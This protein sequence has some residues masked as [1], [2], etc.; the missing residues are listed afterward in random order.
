MIGGHWAFNK[1]FKLIEHI[2]LMGKFSSKS[3][4]IGQS[5]SLFNF[6]GIDGQQSTAYDAYTNSHIKEHHIC[7]NETFISLFVTFCLFERRVFA[8]ANGHCICE[9]HFKLNTTR[10]KTA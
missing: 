4:K 2:E 6:H 8:Y 5:F 10:E 3:V 9:N 7:N 1:N